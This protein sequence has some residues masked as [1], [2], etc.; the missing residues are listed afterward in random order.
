MTAP[1]RL[2]ILALVATAAACASLTPERAPQQN[3]QFRLDRGLSALQSGLYEEAFEDLAWIYSRCSGRRA[4]SRAL[5][6]LAALELDPRN[7]VGRP[8]LG[9]ELLG[10]VIRDPGASEWV[11]PLAESALLAVVAL[12]APHP[13]TDSL[14]AGHAHEEGDVEAHAGLE[15][16]SEADVQAETDADAEPVVGCGPMVETEGWVPPMLPTLTG[17]SMADLLATA[18]QSRDVAV[19]RSDTLQRELAAVREQLE[20]TRA[21]LDRIRETLKP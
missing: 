3:A 18:H 8:D 7:P 6:A 4:A 9:T 5:T 12:G 17:P 20:A 19:A 15:G 13:D 16:L 21:E 10:Q 1:I 2:L 11:R 14:G